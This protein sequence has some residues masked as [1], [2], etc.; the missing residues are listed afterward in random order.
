MFK[1]IGMYNN[2]ASPHNSNYVVFLFLNHQP[3]PFD[4]PAVLGAGG[5]NIDPGG[6]DAAVS[7]DI[8]QLGNILLNA[9]KSTGKELAKIMRKDLGRIYF[10]RMTQSFHLLPDVATIQGFS[11]PGNEN[12]A[13]SDTALLRITQ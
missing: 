6:I 12:C 2:I 1:C 10:R 13:A 8:R 9:V 7:K 11:G 5:H 4:L 3:H